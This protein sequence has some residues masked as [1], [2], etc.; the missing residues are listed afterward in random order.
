MSKWR[1]EEKNDKPVRSSQLITTWGIGSIQS[2]P[3]D[4]SFMLLGL[5]A[6]EYL[7]S[8]PHEFNRDR[9]QEHTIIENRLARRLNVHSFRKPILFNSK[10]PTIM[11]YVRFPRWHYCPRCGHMEQ[12]RPTQIRNLKNPNSNT[13]CPK[14]YDECKNN[15]QDIQLIPSRF[16]LICDKGHIDDFDY[17]YWIKRQAGKDL[18][19]E[20]K[21]RLRRG[22][23]SS[24]IFQ[25]SVECTANNIKAPLDNLFKFYNTSEKGEKCNGAKPWLGIYPWDKENCDKCDSVYKITYRNALNVHSKVIQSSISIPS[26][27]DML[28][29]SLVSDI[30]ERLRYFIEDP[31]MIETEA[32]IQH[33]RTNIPI[34]QIKNYIESLVKNVGNEEN[35]EVSFR[36]DEYK[37]LRSGGGSKSN[38]LF[39]AISKPSP[40][41]KPSLNS[42]IKSISTVHRL[43][44]TSAFV[45][46]NRLVS[47]EIPL[48]SREDDIN[49]L[50]SKLSRNPNINWL[51]A[52]QSK[53]EGI[54]IDFDSTTI[55]KWSKKQSVHERLK[56]IMSNY[57]ANRIERG[58][59]TVNLN[60]AYP[61]IHSFAHLLIDKLSYHCGYGAASLKEKIYTNIS[62]DD[63][64]KMNGLLIYTIGGG[65]G[66][67][68][69]LSSLSDSDDLEKIIVN[70]LVD[71]I[72]CSSD[73]ICIQSEGQGNGLCNLAACHNCL[74]IPET[75]C[76]SFNILLDRGL[77]SERE[78][79]CGFFSDLISSEIDSL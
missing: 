71:S 39:F 5:D 62:V 74:L 17:G 50:K 30:N 63:E 49:E 67:L 47:G 4:E 48:L 1:V 12:L 19:K 31:S 35:N 33:D 6:W 79:G 21:L 27:D 38:N 75:S 52:F 42:L 76:E 53:G 14:I 10:I 66:S 64:I 37:I 68:G 40:F 8:N 58:K 24:T 32:K 61:L 11:P 54:F 43:T 23:T 15:K 25:M 57:N 22:Q 2:F 77:L 45:G 78:G 28:P 69:G 70:A 29:A 72:W 65:D 56:K 46:F 7:F 60:P 16:V 20:P 9:L 3:N 44:E 41:N 18:Q 59:Q 55:E 73:P 36:Y 51:P 13:I 34:P 26:Q